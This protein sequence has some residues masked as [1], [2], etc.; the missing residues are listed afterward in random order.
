MAMNTDTRPR[1]M[2]FS[3]RCGSGVRPKFIDRAPRPD[4]PITL[5]FAQT[6]RAKL[7]G[8]GRGHAK[9]SATWRRFAV[10]LYQTTQFSP[11]PHFVQ[12]HESGSMSSQVR[13]AGPVPSFSVERTCGL[14]DSGGTP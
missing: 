10:Q 7:E 13:A 8:Y 9:M 3:Q 5:D 11:I 14:V 2:R 12:I 4:R 1:R 6:V